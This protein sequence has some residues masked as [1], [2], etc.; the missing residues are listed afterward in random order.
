MAWGRKVIDEYELG[1]YEDVL[2][3]GSF[4]VNGSLRDLLASR[5][6]TYTGMDQFPGPGVDSVG[7]L[8]TIDRGGFP[9][10]LIVCTEVIEHDPRPWELLTIMGELLSPGGHL[11]LTAPSIKF[12]RHNYPGDYYRYTATGLHS[13]A[14]WAGLEVLE[15]AE[16]PGDAHEHG[17]VTRLPEATSVC[18]ASKPIPYS[19]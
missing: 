15:S 14:E 12:P 3:V 2:E 7:N 19:A 11:I 18:L 10:G 13:L 4:N 9:F 16:I 1:W 8:R 17:V 6:N 5:A